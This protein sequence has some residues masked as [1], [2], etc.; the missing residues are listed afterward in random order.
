MLILL[1]S[2][3]FLCQLSTA[4][5]DQF[6]VLVVMSYEQDNPWCEEVKRGIDSVL[7][8][9]SQLNYFYMDTKKNL[10]GGPQ[11]AQEAKA[12][13]EQLQPDGIITVDDNAQ[14]MFAVPFL[15]DKTSVPVMFSGVNAEAEKY[16]YPASNISG[17]L[18]RA[19]I[20][21]SLALTKQLYPSLDTFLVLIKDSPSGK[22]MEKQVNSESAAY[23]AKVDAIKMIKSMEDLDR[24]QLNRVDA[25][26]LIGVAGVID[27]NGSP[28]TYSEVLKKIS[29]IFPKPIIG[30]NQHHVEAGALCAVAKTGHEQGA[31]AA[32][33]LLQ[34]MQGT[35]VADIPVSRNYKG[36]R[37]INVSVMKAL[38]LK[39][40]PTV[41][42]GAEL[43]KTKE[44]L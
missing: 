1:G 3:F 41:L 4:S 28:L 22:A 8:A 14:A 31:T 34:A 17:I 27:E 19:H 39:P 33:M 26:L 36:K 23:L 38:G 24:E 12:L 11:K 13:L 7:S 2:L 40:R 9:S 30:G 15:K 6:K 32:G 20:Q 21:E 25:I 18:E 16:G 44:Q 43:I 37:V 42:I 10:E 35:P 29:A 5:T